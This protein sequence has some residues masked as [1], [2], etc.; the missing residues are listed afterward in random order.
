ML[1][2]LQLF[3]ESC[4]LLEL[5]MNPCTQGCE[6]CYAKTWKRENY[7]IEKVVN[8]ILHLEPKQEGLL[9]FLIR[10]RWPITISNRTDVMCTPDWRERLS[11]IKKLGF[12]ICMETKLNKDYKDLAQILDPK[13]TPS[14][15]Q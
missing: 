8:N 3:G 7:T 6:Y 4:H 12:P 9:P 14:T 13:P 1:Q 2:T 15:R 5:S 10:K 11:A